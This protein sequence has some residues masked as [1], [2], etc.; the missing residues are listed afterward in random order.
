MGKVSLPAGK[1]ANGRHQSSK[2]NTF[3]Y[4]ADKPASKLGPI[5]AKVKVRV[6]EGAQSSSKS[7]PATG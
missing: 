6:V 4:A 5:T 7:R 3:G 2:D 1:T